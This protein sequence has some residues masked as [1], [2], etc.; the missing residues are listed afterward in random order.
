MALPHA[1][2]AVTPST[3]LFTV[4]IVPGYLGFSFMPGFQ[5]G[6]GKFKAKV[7]EEWPSREEPQQPRQ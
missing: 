1:V 4:R 6:L 5:P 7:L 2:T 3:L